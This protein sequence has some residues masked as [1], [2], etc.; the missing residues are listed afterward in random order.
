MTRQYVVPAPQPD[1][2]WT[3]SVF[4]AG[5]QPVT[6]ELAVTSPFSRHQLATVG[7]CSTHEVDQALGA[8]LTAQRTWAAARQAR[9]A[10]LSTAA[11]N[12]RADGDELV[13]WLVHETG[14][15]VAK[16]RLEVN[17]VIAELQESV[18]L[19]KLSLTQP[20]PG[21]KRQSTVHREPIGVVAV[22]A[23]FNFPAHLAVRAIAP[24]LALGNT[25]VLKPHPCAAISGGLW[26]AGMFEVSGL[27][28]GVLSVIPGDAEIS[29]ALVADP[30]VGQVTFT[31]STA[32]GERIAEIAARRLTPTLLELGGN[33]ALVVLPDADVELAASCGGFGSFY[34]QGQ[35]CMS[36]GRH[37]VHESQVDA[38]VQELTGYANRLKI[39]DPAD[40]TNDLGPLINTKQLARV[41]DL[42]R[43]S[44]AAGAELVRGGTTAGLC[45]EPTVLIEPARRSPAWQEEIFGPVAVI[46]PFSDDQDVAAL[47]NEQGPG[48]VTSVLCADVTQGA[49]L[50]AKITCGIVHVNEPTVDYQVGAPFGGWGASGNS[51][52]GDQISNITNFTKTKWL[53][54]RSTM[55]QR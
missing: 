2:R 18:E 33:N 26:L 24:A 25:V 52:I 55:V 12:L 30:R 31:G 5:W 19:A 49:E 38:Y 11:D 47:V 9:I 4:V 10:V 13:A 16:A 37:L 29:E 20:Q 40:P 15:T 51:T 46:S 42:V 41:D 7:E 45:Y 21:S 23:P 27:P 35:I 14:S 43:R 39:G 8:S 34:H 36:T 1:P 32:V 53:T 44:I 6:G 28:T 50:G 22:I 17:L 48:L 3:R 54:V